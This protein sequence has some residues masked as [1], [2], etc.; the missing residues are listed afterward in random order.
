MI[1]ACL[2]ERAADVNVVFHCRDIRPGY[3]ERLE[4]VVHLPC[5][6]FRSGA[7]CRSKFQFSEHLEGH[8]DF[9][10]RVLEKPIPHMGGPAT[11]AGHEDIGIDETCH[12]RFGI[13][14][15]HGS[16]KRANWSTERRVIDGAEGR[17]PLGGVGGCRNLIRMGCE[18]AELLRRPVRQWFRLRAASESSRNSAA[19]QD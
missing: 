4:D 13:K 17:H 15:G 2:F 16:R 6:M 19:H 1:G 11:E 8:E 3:R 9:A 18:A 14:W 10:G 5:M 12:L 7:F